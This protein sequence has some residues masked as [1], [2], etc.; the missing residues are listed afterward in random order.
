LAGST[1]EGA[2]GNLA[3]NCTGFTDWATPAFNLQTG[4]D[5]ASGGT[6]NIFT[7]GSK[8]DSTT[9]TVGFKP[10]DPKND[11]SRFYIS[12]ERGANGHIFMYLAWERGATSGSANEDFEI[13]QN[14]TG[15]GVVTDTNGGLALPIPRT[16]GDLLI[17]Y[18]FSGSSSSPA[19][20]LYK[21][22]SSLLPGQ[23]C[24][25]ASDV[26]SCWV[27]SQ[28]LTGSREAIAAVNG[29][30]SVTDPLQSPAA[31]LG[32]GAFG[33][34]A[35]DMTAAGIF[36]ATKCVH[37]GSAWVKGRSSTQDSSETKDFIAP[38]GVNINNCGTIRIHKVTENGDGTFGYSTTGG[39]T[40]A[41]FN[42][43]NGGTQA[44]TGTVVPGAYSVTE[45]PGPGAWT[46]K[47][48]SST[49]TG[50]GTIASTSGA[51]ASI[52][53]GAS[54]TV[55]IT[56]TNHINLSPSIS[57][58]LSAT[59]VSIGT[60]VSDTATLSGA[61]ANAGGTV[62][63]TVFS[64][65]A[66]SNQVYNAGSGTVSNGMA[67]SAPVIFNNAGT[68]YWQAVYSGD[69]NNNPATSPC[70]S[71][72]LT[73]TKNQPGISTAQNLIPN[74]AA[75]ISGA[76]SAV[77][78][79]ITFQLFSP[80]N[81]TC[82]STIGNPALTQTVSVNHGNGTYPTTNTTVIASDPGTWKWKVVY[83]GDANNAGTTSVCGVENF[84]ITN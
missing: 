32:A 80:S 56:Y 16:A 74:D 82:N 76:T 38:I 20:T 7:G 36:P 28:D 71:E 81:P 23:S 83:S 46:L 50:P 55:D 66:C 45:S 41:T 43:S 3:V 57:T 24:L 2:D 29:T 27:Y 21:W 10:A 5:L 73:V 47:S 67:Y 64:D 51:T 13:N 9:P 62:T 25:T 54:G 48:V 70:M 68:Y 61:T 34:A 63:F 59:S 11:L 12:N 79:T 22:Q 65:S 30:S 15:T 4:I 78:G 8:E 44:Y 75:T 33:E 84:T 60:P 39:L 72:V 1:F 69:A 42:L 18:D 77:T 49:V 35:I 58:T 31:T 53:M 40:P 26:P 14:A 52:T 37:F 17:A 6:D 19:L